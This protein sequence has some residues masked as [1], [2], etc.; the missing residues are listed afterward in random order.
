MGD[1]QQ[2]QQ[3][4]RGLLASPHLPD[5]SRAPPAVQLQGEAFNAILSAANGTAQ[6]SDATLSGSAGS[7]D[8]GLPVGHARQVVAPLLLACH[9][10]VVD[11]ERVGD[12]APNLQ[13]SLQLAR[14]RRIVAREG[15]TCPRNPA[16]AGFNLEL[17]D[18]DRPL[19]RSWRAPHRHGC[20]TT[21]S[22]RLSP[23]RSGA[24]AVPHTAT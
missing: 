4:P 12:L 21:C 11:P 10:L 23:T 22:R 24:G 14:A 15:G 17:A 3:Q 2:H 1:Q 19:R 8:G 20:R 9:C 18:V 16:R 6:R 5:A 7:H 13:T